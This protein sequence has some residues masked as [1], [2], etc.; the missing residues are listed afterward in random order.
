MFKNL[1]RVMG[2]MSR[3]WYGIVSLTWYREVFYFDGCSS[4]KF[5][6]KRGVFMSGLMP[7][8]SLDNSVVT[9]M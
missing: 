1:E 7:I 3:G 8:S 2:F 9:C 6:G 4:G 5:V